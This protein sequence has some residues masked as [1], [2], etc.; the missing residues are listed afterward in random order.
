M[1]HSTAQLRAAQANAALPFPFPLASPSISC[2]NLLG[3]SRSPLSLPPLQLSFYSLRELNSICELLFNSTERN[4]RYQILSF[5]KF[6]HIIINICYCSLFFFF[7]FFFLFFLFLLFNSI[8][9]GF[10]KYY[11]RKISK[12]IRGRRAEEKLIPRVGHKCIAL[13]VVMS[14]HPIVS[15]HIQVQYFA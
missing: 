15:T 12:N 3:I 7:L 5:P 9:L 4:V 8:Q 1:Q 2:T 14:N 10:Q 6:T 11:S 13:P